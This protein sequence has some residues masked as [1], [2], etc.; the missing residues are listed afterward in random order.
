MHYGSIQLG[1]IT[2]SNYLPFRILNCCYENK[3]FYSKKKMSIDDLQM[4]N[5]WSSNILKADVVL[6]V[7]DIFIQ[8]ALFEGEIIPTRSSSPAFSYA[9]N[10][11]I[12][13]MPFVSNII[14][15]VIWYKVFS[16]NYL[17]LV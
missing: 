10:L 7:T 16:K 14:M 2:Q 11:F 12:A 15:S 8:G 9:P 13:W 5:S 4:Q 1:I 3:I 6:T 17:G